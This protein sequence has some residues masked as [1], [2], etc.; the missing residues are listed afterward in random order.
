MKLA[1]EHKYRPT[2]RETLEDTRKEAAAVA[3]ERAVRASH[4]RRWVARTGGI[5]SAQMLASV[6][7]QA[8]RTAVRLLPEYAR[9]G[10]DDDYQIGL[11]SVRW[12]G[13]GR[14]HVP[15]DTDLSVA[16]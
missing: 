11:L 3:W 15:A 4:L 1:S 5:R 13:R 6:K 2:F 7:V 12:I 14:L 10:L 16:G 9:V 8:L